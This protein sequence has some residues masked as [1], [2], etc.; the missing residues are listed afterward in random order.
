MQFGAD[1]R[2]APRSI[3]QVKNS[4]NSSVDD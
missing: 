1:L 3:A 2:R 4:R